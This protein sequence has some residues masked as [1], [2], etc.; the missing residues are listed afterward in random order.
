MYRR[1]DNVL[2]TTYTSE[3]TF[4]HVQS[5][6]VE[7]KEGTKSDNDPIREYGLDGLEIALFF[8]LQLVS[9]ESEDDAFDSEGL[10]NVCKMIHVFR[11]YSP[12]PFN[13]RWVKVSKTP[14]QKTKLCEFFVGCR[15]FTSGHKVL[16]ERCFFRCS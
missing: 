16:L 2:H 7:I 8:K 9:T 13:C 3:G 11:A 6:G 4:N 10:D 5:T 15:Q 12:P 14:A 1:R